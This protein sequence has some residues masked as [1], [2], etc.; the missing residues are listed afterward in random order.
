M[1][2]EP[3][4]T[5]VIPTV[6]RA[7]CVGRAIESA[8]NQTYQNLDIIVSDNGSS[9]ETPEVLRQFHDPRLRHF[10]RDDTIPS[11]DH[12]NFLVEAARG[13][14]FLGL[15][16]DDFLEADFVR[17]AIARY[18]TEP[19]VV[20]TYSRCFV[21]YRD[22][23]TLS[24][25]APER[26]SG[27][28]FV[29][30]YLSGARDIC[31]CAC[32][33]RTSDMREAGPM[34]AGRIFG[35]MFFWTKVVF[36]GVI[37]FVPEPLSHYVYYDPVTMNTSHSSS[38]A[39]WIQDLEHFDAVLLEGY[40]CSGNS[41]ESIDQL[42]GLARRSTADKAA[43]QFVWLAIRGV[44]RIQLIRCLPQAL[45]VLSS[46]FPAVRKIIASFLLPRDWLLAGMLRSIKRV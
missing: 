35:D 20:L 46:S 3:L 31:W 39:S 30:A 10:R 18:L 7:K 8:L 34:P 15:S 44:P 29:E 1:E 43:N 33:L 40:R 36:R 9:D 17:R 37:A 42:I 24:A 6:N 23:R 2:T 27:F 19:D 45:G 16:D 32:I 28:E 21:H 13:E 25:P 11:V 41:A 12:A 14:F 4:V 26:E 38:I 22:Q 5:I